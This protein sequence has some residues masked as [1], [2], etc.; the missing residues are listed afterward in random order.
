MI[1]IW[2]VRVYWLG[3]IGSFAIRVGYIGYTLSW[4][5]YIGY[6][7]Y[8]G[9]IGYT[10]YWI[11]PIGYK[12]RVYWIVCY[13]DCQYLHHSLFSA[14]SKS[15]WWDLPPSTPKNSVCTILANLP[16]FETVFAAS[17]LLYHDCCAALS[18]IATPAVL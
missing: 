16:V 10:L 18:C 3:Y 12:V 14:I 11:Y 13:S 15:E 6:T 17:I 9:Y 7:L 5:P 2:A 4:I 8:V 1:C